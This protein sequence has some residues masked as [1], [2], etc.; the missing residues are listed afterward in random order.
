MTS[1]ENH[2]D[3]LIT[4]YFDR[5]WA[6]EAYLG[7]MG[8]LLKQSFAAR[9]QW[10]KQLEQFWSAWQLPNQEMQQR[11]LHGVNTLL[12]EWRFEQ[13]EVN[14]RLAK[15]ESDIAELK[16]LVAQSVKQPAANAAAQAQAP[17]GHKGN[18]KGSD[19]HNGG[20]N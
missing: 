13:E 3:K 9:A 4:T 14:E 1:R 6:N 17:K 20:Q 16:D 19:K 2:F 10:N 7:A 8:G 5:L 11:T 18:D 12:T 15:M